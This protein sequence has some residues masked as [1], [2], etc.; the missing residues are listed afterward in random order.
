MLTLEKI[1]GTSMR[2][3]DRILRDF[4][5]FTE[6]G[7]VIYNRVFVVSAFAGVTDLLLE[8]KKTG[9][10]GVYHR[11]A[12]YNDFQAPLDGVTTRLKEIHQAYEPLGLDLAAADRFVTQRVA[13]AQAFLASLANVLASGYVSAESIL[14]AAREILASI[15]EAHAGFVFTNVL[16]RN[17][18]AATFLDLSG[19]HD[20]G[21]YTIDERIA[22]AF[23][24]LDLGQTIGVVTGYTKGVE[25]I[26]REFDRGY[27]EVTFSK[28]AVA[29]KPSSTRS[30]TSPR[31]TRPWWAWSTACRWSSPTTR[32]PTS[33]RT[34]AW[35][36][37]T[38]R[39]AS[40]WRCTASTC[41]S[42]TPLNPA[43]RVP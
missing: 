36:R 30:T 31:P 5:F 33:W 37:S 27:S 11:F 39:P 35:R 24:D 32:W 29:L 22:H 18:M 19:F 4:Q 34:W 23:K 8:N 40:R 17:G 12:Q 43:T 21:L 41:G 10:P 9:E 42:R 1:D 28:I 15:G 2:A 25:G 14:L 16:Q 6:S 13:E 7:E 26:M 38:P 20:H 3:L